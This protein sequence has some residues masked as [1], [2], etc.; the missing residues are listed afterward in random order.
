MSKCY[1]LSNQKLLHEINVL[2]Q[3]IHFLKCRTL[4]SP[5]ITINGFDKLQ[6]CPLMKQN[7]G[8]PP[9]NDVRQLTTSRLAMTT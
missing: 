5:C 8:D 1:N 4:T 7:S 2:D 6:I 3:N 9:I